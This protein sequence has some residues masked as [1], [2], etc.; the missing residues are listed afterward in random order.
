M[1]TP[2]YKL[3]YK[4]RESPFTE[5]Q[6]NVLHSRHPSRIALRSSSTEIKTVPCLA[7]LHEALSVPAPNRLNAVRVRHERFPLARKAGHSES[8]PRRE[9]RVIWQGAG[10]PG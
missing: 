6:D 8:Q 5:N 4:L 3:D 9:S 10:V 1:Y 7:A 2:I